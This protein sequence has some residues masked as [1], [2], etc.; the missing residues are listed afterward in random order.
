MLSVPFPYIATTAGWLTTELGRQPWLVYG[1]LHTAD[2]VSPLV[3]SGNALFTLIW[4]LGL[5]LFLG[6]LFLFL[7]AETIRHGPAEPAASHDGKV[8]DVSKPA[9]RVQGHAYEPVY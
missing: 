3:H 8:V 9:A 1:L 7:L 4:F 5:Y 2:G 6:L